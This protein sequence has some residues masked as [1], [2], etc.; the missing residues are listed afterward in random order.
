MLFRLERKSKDGARKFL[1]AVFCAVIPGS[2]VRSFKLSEEP[3][4]SIFRVDFT[5]SFPEYFIAR[6]VLEDIHD[7]CLMFVATVAVTGIFH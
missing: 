6:V 7:L 2:L 4:S 1:S 5:V 3:A